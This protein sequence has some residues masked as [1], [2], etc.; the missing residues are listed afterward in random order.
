MKLVN[1]KTSESQEGFAGKG[2]GCKATLINGEATIQARQ[3]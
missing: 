1:K 3:K 2:G